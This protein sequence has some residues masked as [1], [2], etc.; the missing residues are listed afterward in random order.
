MLQDRA[1]D[2]PQDMTHDTDDQQPSLV[3]G[4]K[5]LTLDSKLDVQH[6]TDVLASTPEVPEEKNEGED[7][8][9]RQSAMSMYEMTE[10]ET[11]LQKKRK[12]STE[13]I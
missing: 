2:T 8:M 6:S 4:I 13:S 10:Q 9:G 1:Q 3:N 7:G 11:Q 12:K 5:D